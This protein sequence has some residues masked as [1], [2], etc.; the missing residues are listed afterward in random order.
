MYI[1]IYIYIYIYMCVCV[2][3]YIYIYMLHN[4]IHISHIS[5][6]IRKKY[7]GCNIFEIMKTITNL[8]HNKDGLMANCAPGTLD[9]AHELQVL[10][11]PEL[12]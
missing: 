6:Y 2:Y 3:I 9:D 1:Y 10:Q 8:A 7:G 5:C 11:V 12:L 4:I